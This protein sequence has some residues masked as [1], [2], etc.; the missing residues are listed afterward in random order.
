[1]ISKRVMREG[2]AGNH[3]FRWRSPARSRPASGEGLTLKEGLTVL[4]SRHGM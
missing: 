1:M 3:R 2:R 4:G